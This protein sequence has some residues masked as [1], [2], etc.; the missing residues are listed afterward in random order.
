[1]RIF[2]NKGYIL[3]LVFS[4]IIIGLLSMTNLH[5]LRAPGDFNTGHKNLA[6]I[7]CHESADGSIRQQIQANLSYLLGQNK[8][9]T[10]FNFSP[11]NNKDCLACHEREDDKHP[12]YRFNEPRFL[13]ARNAIQPQYCVSCH[14]EHTGVRVSSKPNNCK[15]CHEEIEVKD[16]PLD[17]SHEDL[18]K[19][20]DWDT[21]LTCH[22]FH[23]NHIMDTPINTKDML[24]KNLI[25]QYLDG[26]EDP[27]SEKKTAKSKETR[28][29]D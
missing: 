12:V 3:G 21:C 11:P 27:Y 18:I 10:A 15:Y 6:C 8:K 2:A 9:L 17:I 19:L 7:E 14:K 1:M 29:E 22:D 24:D 25:Q 23:G 5:H 16:D 26:G 4:V 20:K 28:Y 13:E